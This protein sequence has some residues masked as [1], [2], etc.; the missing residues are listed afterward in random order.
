MHLLIHIIV[1]SHSLTILRSSNP[2]LR[3]G[4]AVRC[5]GERCNIINESQLQLKWSVPACCMMEREAAEYIANT[6]NA[7]DAAAYTHC[8]R[9]R[10]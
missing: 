3:I 6:G 2:H 1:N 9:R 4:Y 5:S 10:R 7:T 8:C